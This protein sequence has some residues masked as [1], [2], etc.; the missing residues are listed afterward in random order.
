MTKTPNMWADHDEF[1]KA[2]RAKWH[3]QA[4]RCLEERKK[5]RPEPKE[6][7]W[8]ENSFKVLQDD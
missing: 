8:S 4:V 2:R 3:A 6:K 5:G 7:P 1:S